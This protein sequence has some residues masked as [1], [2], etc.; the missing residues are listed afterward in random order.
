[1]KPEELEALTTGKT[2]IE[3]LRV[4][5]IL[6]KKLL[7]CEKKRLLGVGGKAGLSGAIRYFAARGV[8]DWE[9]QQ[10]KS[11]GVVDTDK[12]GN[13]FPV[14]R[15]RLLNTLLAE[16]AQALSENIEN[17]PASSGEAETHGTSKPPKEDQ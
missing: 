4:P 2:R 8:L 13:A 9:D 5:V 14:A 15:L 7:D 6:K 1:M 11:K 10:R 3:S 12:S 16:Q 17:P